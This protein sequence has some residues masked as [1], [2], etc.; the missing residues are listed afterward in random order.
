VWAVDTALPLPV[1]LAGPPSATWE[2]GEPNLVSLGGAPIPVRVAG[3]AAALPVLG[4]NG[5]LVDLEASRR[6]VGDANP[7]AQYQV[8]LAPGAGRAVVDRLV[9]A[10]IDVSADQ[11]VASR[12][13]QLAEQAP[14]AVT[15]FSLI[16]GVVALLLAAAAIGVAGAVDRR[17]RLAQL[18][19][20]RVQGLAGRTAVV[21]A[22]AGP[23]VLIGAGLIGGLL[24]S[25]IA[26]PLARITVPAFTDGWAVLAPPSALGG[27]ALLLAGIAAL[28]A[29]G[30]I[31]WLSVLPL[32][33]RL[34]RRR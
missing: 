1:V 31:G 13:A 34:G 4:R 28:V 6:I 11:S 26:R 20:L 18:T 27:M 12:S 33:L 24:A 9:K 32:L 2:F 5:V 7:P 15:R 29:L 25:A 22:Y 14:A 3:T 19:A 8:W 30:L 23:A 17:I 10:G 16:C 21:T